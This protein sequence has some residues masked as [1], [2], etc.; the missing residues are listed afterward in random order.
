MNKRLFTLLKR[1]FTKLGLIAD[2]VVEE[3]TS[4]I[5]TYRKWNS[6]KAELWGQEDKVG[7]SLNTSYANKYYYGSFASSSFPF[8]LLD[9]QAWVNLD[10][11]GVDWV[12]GVSTNGDR[13]LY[14]WC[15]ATSY[16]LTSSSDA[17]YYVVGYWKTPT[18]GGSTS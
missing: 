12:G 9:A 5:W 3:G 1:A 8:E 4:G 18:W 2:Y 7:T 14:Q 6:G 13:V 15:N 16:T 10:G 11:S 17:Q